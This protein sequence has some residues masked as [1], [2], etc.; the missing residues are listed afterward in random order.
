[1]AVNDP[2]LMFTGAKN[3]DTGL[4]LKNFFYQLELKVYNKF[5]GW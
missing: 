1:M 2:C 5:I 4:G 3:S